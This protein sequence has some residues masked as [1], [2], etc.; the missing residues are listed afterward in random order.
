MLSD[1][2]YK[3]AEQIEA[4]SKYD[5]KIRD[6]VKKMD[7]VQLEKKKLREQLTKIDKDEDKSLY[8][9]LWQKLQ[10]LF[11]EDN[12]LMKQWSNI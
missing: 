11:A 10:Q 2:I 7:I 1:E 4:E 6:I 5:K 12:K 9:K 8:E 3:I